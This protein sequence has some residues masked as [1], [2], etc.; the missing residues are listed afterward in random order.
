MFSFF[1]ILSGIYVQMFK[2]QE[3]GNLPRPRSVSFT[4]DKNIKIT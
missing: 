2:A 3:W 1:L 4:W